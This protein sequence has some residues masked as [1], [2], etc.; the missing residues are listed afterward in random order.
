MSIPSEL[1]ARVRRALRD[2]GAL[3]DE[4]PI[5]WRTLREWEDAGYPGGGPGA[6]GAGVHTDPTARAALRRVER[7]NA[8]ETA[9][10]RR[11]VDQ[12]DAI[13]HGLTRA[14]LLAT[15]KRVEALED[16][17]RCR[18]CARVGEIE[19]VFAKHLC[20]WCYEFDLAHGELPHVQLLRVH[21]Q[22]R[23]RVTTALVEQYHGRNR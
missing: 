16:T 2:I 19:D 15:T 7:G 9:T 18:S 20:R 5:I 4:L 11:L 17:P 10:L 23:G 13:E 3:V 8:S 22:P 12:L 6:H 14:H 21:H 1:Q